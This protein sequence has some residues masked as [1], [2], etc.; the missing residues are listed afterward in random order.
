MRVY[1]STYKSYNDGNLNG[2]WMD[3]DNFSDYDE[4]IEACRELF[5]D[6]EDPEEIEL[7]FQD[8]DSELPEWAYSENEIDSRLWDYIDLDEDDK[9]K[10]N[11]LVEYLSYDIDEAFDNYQDVIF[12]DGMTLTA[13]AEELVDE[14]LF[15]EV[16]DNLKWYLDYEA[17]ARDLERDGYT[18]TSD[19]VFFYNG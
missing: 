8:K 9:L 5:E 17:I 2:R 3:I 4:F 11:Y 15:G 10:F 6:E 14:G 16:S 13:V 7:M 1:V 12:Y 18:E 19:G